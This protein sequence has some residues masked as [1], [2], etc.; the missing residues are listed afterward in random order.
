M[1]SPRATPL[2]RA[3][4]T[5]WRCWG[6][7]FVRDQNACMTDL[8]AVL[9][10]LGIEPIGALDTDL[11]DVV[12]YREAGVTDEANQVPTADRPQ[13]PEP[14]PQKSAPAVSPVGEKA[15][16]RAP[17]IRMDQSQL[18][19][20]EADLPLWSAPVKQE[21]RVEIGDSVRYSFA[22]DPNDVSFATLV[23]EPSNPNIGTMNR[24]T[25][26]GRALL[27]M[28]ANDEKE[29]ALPT[30]RRRLRVIEIL[31]PTRRVA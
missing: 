6:S 28:V 26:V 4:W 16:G 11:S 25:V 10:G 5:F 15:G 8:V 22:D 29:I 27:G 30:G 24:D 21:P 23:N 13:E 17:P 12:E 31:K 1:R 3:G 14:S 2:E 7:S 20:T 9:K 18:L 19:P